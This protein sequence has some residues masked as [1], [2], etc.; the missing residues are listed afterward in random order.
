MQENY[1]SYRVCEYEVRKRGIHIYNTPEE[2]GR[3]KTWMTAGWELYD[4]L[5]AVGYRDHPE[6]GERVLF[7]TYPHA[8]YTVLINTRPYDK[9][10]ME[11]R[12]Q[13]QLVL[14]EYGVDVPDAIKVMMEWTRHRFL[15]GNIDV[16]SLYNHDALDALLAAYTAYLL[17]QEPHAV[18]TI[19]DTTDGVMVLPVASLSD[20][21]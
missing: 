7:E 3:L 2:A 10:S 14:Y 8:G 18:I 16:V 19:G 11:G 13:R 6:A 1:S 12:M 20:A 17:D 9:N 5:R 21:Y 4:Q 15:T